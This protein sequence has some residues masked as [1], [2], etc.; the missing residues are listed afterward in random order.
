MID[1]FALAISHGLMM[2]AAWLLLRR[3]DL[4]KEPSRHDVAR[5]EKGKRGA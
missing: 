1:N 3:D 5:P 2:L 4:D